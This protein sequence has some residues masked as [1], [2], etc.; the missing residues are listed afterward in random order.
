MSIQM[1]CVIP[2]EVVRESQLV[3]FV[4]D[5]KIEFP[6]IRLL[7]VFEKVKEQHIAR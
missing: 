1:K 7:R 3:R 4:P 5:G 6:D 2:L